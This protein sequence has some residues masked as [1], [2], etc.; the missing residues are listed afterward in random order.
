MTDALDDHASTISISGRVITNLQFADDI[1]G[2][3]GIEEQWNKLI[4]CLDRTAKAFGM[5]INA[6]KTKLMTNNGEGIRGDIR[7]N[8]KRLE[9]VNQS[10]TLV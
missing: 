7:I 9:R 8:D 4:K 10:S 3:A 2:L 1:D 5:E 6:E